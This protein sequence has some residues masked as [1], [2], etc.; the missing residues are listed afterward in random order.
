MSD[1]LKQKGVNESYAS[2]LL[3]H[4]NNSQTFGRYGKSYNVELL[5]KETVSKLDYP[6]IDW[7]QL[8][9]EFK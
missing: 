5:L 4:S 6:G 3:G 1:E 7:M 8:K 9:K 2:E